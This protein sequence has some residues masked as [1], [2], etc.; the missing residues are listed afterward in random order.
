MSWSVSGV[1]AYTDV[2]CPGVVWVLWRAIRSSDS[3]YADTGAVFMAPF[4]AVPYCN[5]DGTDRSLDLSTG[6][7]SDWPSATNTTPDSSTW[8][9]FV[10]TG[11]ATAIDPSTISFTPGLTSDS[12]ALMS[13]PLTVMDSSVT[14]AVSAALTAASFTA[15]GYATSGALN[16][17]SYGGV[18]ALDDAQVGSHINVGDTFSGGLI[19]NT[20]AGVASIISEPA[21]YVSD[22][23]SVATIAWASSDN[24]NI[25]ITGVGNCNLIAEFPSLDAP[26]LGQ[27]IPVTIT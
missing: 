20:I 27:T 14:S 8:G 26:N 17:T 15:V 6:L 10:A 21:T 2:N 22:N 16:F 23:T 19:T 9:A 4:C 1:N 25:T 11:L 7:F 3:K 18:T 5:P 12:D 13:V 24:F